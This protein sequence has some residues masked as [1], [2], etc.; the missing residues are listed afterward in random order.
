MGEAEATKKV[1]R[2][3][4]LDNKTI[5]GGGKVPPFCVTSVKAR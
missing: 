1:K 4:A 5:A 2:N 3:G